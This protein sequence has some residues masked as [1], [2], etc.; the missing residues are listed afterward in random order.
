MNNDNLT[1]AEAGYLRAVAKNDGIMDTRKLR[2]RLSENKSGIIGM[3]ALGGI[4]KVLKRLERKGFLT[5]MNRETYQITQAG[6]D[7]LKAV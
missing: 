7:I 2:N 4:C 3:S 5:Q 1:T 6:L